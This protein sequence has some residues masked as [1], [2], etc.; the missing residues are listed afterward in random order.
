[1]NHGGCVICA[2]GFALGKGE[3]TDDAND[4]FPTPKTTDRPTSSE[5]DDRGHG[6]RGA[7]DRNV[8]GCRAGLP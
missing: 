2:G 1:M 4:K 7:S 5:N 6:K 3:E 8:T